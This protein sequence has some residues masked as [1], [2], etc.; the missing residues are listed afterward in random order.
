MPFR[1]RGLSRITEDQ[2]IL[3]T[4][5]DFFITEESKISKVIVMG[6]YNRHFYLQ[7]GSK[8]YTNLFMNSSIK[9]IYVLGY[10]MLLHPSYSPNLASSD[11]FLFQMLWKWSAV[12]D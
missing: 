10:D 5:V 8:Y 2:V 1:I 6:K 12:R 4:V 9:K 3:K 7:K 11:H